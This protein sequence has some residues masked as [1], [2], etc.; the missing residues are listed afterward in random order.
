MDLPKDGRLTLVIC[1]VIS[2]IKT[3][4]GTG[5]MG[6]LGPMYSF[7][8]RV[9]GPNIMFRET[10]VYTVRECHDKWDQ[11][12]CIAFQYSAHT[13][14]T[15]QGCKLFSGNSLQAVLVPDN[16]TD[17]YWTNSWHREEYMKRTHGSCP[18]PKGKFRQ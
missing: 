18:I 13:S 3:N 2:I 11:D 14:S 1:C 7:C 15:K 9:E 16:C 6:C 8:H 17:V 4:L 10:K 12:Q 5:F